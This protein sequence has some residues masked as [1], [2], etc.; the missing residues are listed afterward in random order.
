MGGGG[1]VFPISVTETTIINSNAD[2]AA[3]K[4]QR[5]KH[6]LVSPTVVAHAFI[7]SRGLR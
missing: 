7:H 1:P 5:I 4:G 3:G 6:G 2:R